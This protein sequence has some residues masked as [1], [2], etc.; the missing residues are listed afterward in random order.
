[1]GEK[2]GAKPDLSAVDNKV[3]IV[4]KRRWRGQRVWSWPD[5]LHEAEVFSELELAGAKMSN[6]SI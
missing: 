3:Q 6:D 1:M 2:K 5:L 4:G